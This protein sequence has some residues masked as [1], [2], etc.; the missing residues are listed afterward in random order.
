MKKFLI[1]TLFISAAI[2]SASA[3][4]PKISIEKDE[5]L[6][7]FPS[8]IAYNKKNDL[9]HIKV[10]AWVCEPEFDSAT[11]KIIT[12][13]AKKHMNLSD[14]D[15]ETRNFNE[16]FRL[17]MIDQESRKSIS[18]LIGTSYY[19][20]GVTDTNGHTEREI[21]LPS[22]IFYSIINHSANNIPDEAEVSIFSE[23]KT[24][25]RVFEG[26]A[27]LIKPEGVM[28]LTDIDDTIKISEVYDKNKLLRNVFVNEYKPVPKMQKLFSSWKNKG[29]DF[30]YLTASPWQLFPAIQSFITKEKFPEGLIQMKSFGLKDGY[31]SIF[32]SP[33]KFKTPIILRIM[34]D[35]PDKKF[36]L[37]G[38][39]FEKDPEIYA[40]IARK[41]PGRIS[42]IFIRNTSSE[43]RESDRMK[44]A[45]DKI[46]QSL[47]S[48][49][50][51]PS[52]IET[53]SDNLFH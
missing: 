19:N 20:I 45:F 41:N 34:K 3:K 28:V 1:L 32:E 53:S 13:A 47:W 22:N 9:F 46:D 29:A 38:D 37:I 36:I 31:L 5:E 6:Y 23:A 17:F 11:R 10:H 39:S 25:G 43:S 4:P 52:E 18:A 7:Y 15:I 44:K 2:F 27:K 24:D 49:F 21:V 16:R 42:Q 14:D 12:S 33:E 35:F 8:Y 30:T 26:K 51:D 40:D 48:L 50:S